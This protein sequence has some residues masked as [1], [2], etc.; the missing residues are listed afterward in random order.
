MLHAW[1]CISLVAGRRPTALLCCSRRWRTLRIPSLRCFTPHSQGQFQKL[2]LYAQTLAQ[3]SLVIS[4]ARRPW[5][6]KSASFSTLHHE[7]LAGITRNCPNRVSN[8]ASRKRILMEWT[9]RGSD[10]ETDLGGDGYLELNR[11]VVKSNS[12]VVTT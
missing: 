1:V 3:H 10:Q 12:T 5:G 7:K 8:A 2:P 4:T 9:D 11:T 6:R